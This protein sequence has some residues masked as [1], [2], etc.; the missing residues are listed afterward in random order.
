MSELLNKI[1]LSILAFVVQSTFECR[2]KSRI[3][4]SVAD[5]IQS[6]VQVTQPVAQIPGQRWYFIIFKG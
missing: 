4:G 3:T 1:Q 5:R 6:G 2:A